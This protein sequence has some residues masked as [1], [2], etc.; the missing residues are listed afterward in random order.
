MTRIRLT[1]KRQA[2]L[3]RALC[4]EMRLRAGDSIVVDA[5][6]VGGE[7]VWLLKPATRIET[8]W[9]ARLKRYARHKKHDLASIRKSVEQAR[10]DGRI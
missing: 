4:E 9:F 10:R 2:T 7:R 6:V 5:R 3:P 8:P 1:S